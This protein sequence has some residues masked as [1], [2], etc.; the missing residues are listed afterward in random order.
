MNRN[1]PLAVFALIALVSNGGCAL[2]GDR[3]PPKASLNTVNA[4]DALN[5]IA[6]SEAPTLIV[7]TLTDPAYG[8]LKKLR[9]PRNVQPGIDGTYNE[10]LGELDD[11]YGVRLVADW[12]L[13]SLG[14]RCLVFRSTSSLPRDHI[15][16]ALAKD[17]RVE[18]AQPMN[19][20]SVLASSYDDP[21]FKL[22]HNLAS[23][24]VDVSHRW[25]TGKGVTVAVIDSGVD[26][27]HPELRGRVAG[28]QNFVLDGD[29]AFKSDLHGTAVAGI[30]AAESNNGTGIVGVAPDAQILALKAC[31]QDTPGTIGASCSTFT[32]AK[33]IDFAT[34]QGVSVI[35]LS[36]SGPR[37]PL[38][39]RLVSTAVGTGTVVVGARNATRPGDFPASADGV[40]GVGEARG[41]K[42]SPGS[43]PSVRA[44]GYKVLSTRPKDE[45]DFF[46]GSS[47]AAAHVSGLVALLKAKNPDLSPE[48]ILS[49]LKD[50]SG[51][52]LA[53]SGGGPMVNACRAMAH[54]IDGPRC[55][56]AIVAR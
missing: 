15:I 11:R 33:A 19:V 52:R 43:E 35:N 9:S 28:W 56:S 50:T 4:M 55:E 22:Q 8:D 48:N 39:E 21:Y 3:T 25:S 12:P 36:L 46:S 41:A 40:I 47:L 44:P 54:L 53:G 27:T 5:P 31:W 37:D 2:I 26:V 17:P 13:G 16:A 1:N 49:L 20:F 10:F 29:G 32:L 6:T 24:Q 51:G 38:L 34:S 14:V 42:S 30:V 45:Y 7:A 23:M 18:T